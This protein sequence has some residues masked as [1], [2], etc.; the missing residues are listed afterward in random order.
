MKSLRLVMLGLGPW[1]LMGAKAPIAPELDTSDMVAFEVSDIEMGWPDTAVGPYGDGWFID[2]QPLQPVRVEAFH[3]DLHEV[4]VSGFA[5]FLTYAAGDL[6]ADPRQP[7]TRN[8]GGY[9]ALDGHA[10]EP[11]RH[12]SWEAARD[13]CRWVGK[14]LPTEA[15]F[16]RA[17]RGLEGRSWPWIEGGI[18]CQ[19]AN[20]FTNATH[21]QSGPVDVASHPDGASPEGVHD[22]AG[23]V[24]EWVADSYGPY[25]EDAAAAVVTATDELKVV[26]GGGWRD[27]TL[28][29]RSHA[30]R[31]VSGALRSD[32]IGF[33]C[34]WSTGA[35]LEA[36]R[37]EL[38]TLAEGA[39]RDPEE[40][41]AEAAWT[42]I[43]RLTGLL[44]PQG[45][46]YLSGRWY[47]SD[48]GHGQLLALDAD[49]PDALLI[50]EGLAEPTH[51][52]ASVDGLWIA[53]STEPRVSHWLL[54]GETLDHE[55]TLA[56]S[57]TALATFEGGVVV[58]TSAG[59][60]RIDRQGSET[61]LVTDLDGVGAL[62][63][64]ND[65]LYFSEW[66]DQD[67]SRARLGAISLNG[68]TASS[69]I[70]QSTLQ[71]VLSVSALS[72][73]VD[74]GRLVLALVRQGWPYSGVVAQL[75]PEGGGLQTMSHGPPRMG[76]ILSL[77]G[78]YVVGCERTVIRV[79][80]GQPYE[81]LT[82]WA[83]V[84]A[85]ATDGQGGIAWTDKRAGVLWLH[86]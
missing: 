3:L 41:A 74:A 63:V 84:S 24:A 62:A 51:L 1:L 83:A 69:V 32:N 53:E 70:D 56:E 29:L 49:S 61:W 13:Y 50:L 4:T 35:T 36:I 45:V 65:T 14:R 7:V 55:S 38:P 31:A 9:R 59:I 64:V 23:N 40:P 19:R 80:A 26:R 75:N 11:I 67:L 33:R 16:E 58:A 15:E 22:L 28:A 57:P 72:W 46:A 21:C 43:R 60:V 44:N 12:V 25:A 52:A 42:P 79:A 10:N 37:G 85:L 30:R 34:A 82:P 66:G 8:G 54:G 73:D 39:S 2:Q 17:A 68:G 47:V 86:P 48:T 18:N 27:A 5:R 76:A 6:Y 71:G 20:Y 81:V 77:N 78:T